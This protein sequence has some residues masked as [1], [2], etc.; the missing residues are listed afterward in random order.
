M[1]LAVGDT[2]WELVQAYS[3]AMRQQ[4]MWNE[5]YLLPALAVILLLLLA[6]Y[7]YQRIARRNKPRE[8][9]KYTDWW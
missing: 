4:E 7:L 8:K 5:Q 2:T 6:V 9:N 1:V 3:K